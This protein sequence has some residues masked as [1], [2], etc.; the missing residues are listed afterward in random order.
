MKALVVGG[1]G[2]GK[3]QFAEDLACTLGP[4]RT[5]VATMAPGSAEAQARIQRHRTQRAGRGFVTHECLGT[6]AGHL[7]AGAHDDVVLL[8]DM[9]NLVANALFGPDG[10]MGDPAQVVC[11][12][13]RELASLCTCH[14][15]VVVVGDQAG[16]DG[17]A[18]SDQTAAWL[19]ACGTL[20]CGMAARA[21]VVAEVVC[22]VP[23]VLKGVLP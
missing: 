2:S 15:H 13:E 14:R 21:D 4:K 8:D 9:G 11:R 7:V 23:H 20:C 3:S 1:S 19:H 12:L 10:R 22:G 6:I 5:Y 17:I 18:P 16:S